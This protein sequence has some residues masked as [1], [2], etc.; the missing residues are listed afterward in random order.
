MGTTEFQSKLLGLHDN[1]LNFAIM[2][3]SN[4]ENAYDLVQ[5]TTLKAL[6]SEDK[7]TDDSNF[8]GWD[9][10]QKVAESLNDKPKDGE[11]M[12]EEQREAAFAEAREQKAAEQTEVTR[13]K[14]DSETFAALTAAIGLEGSRE[15]PSAQGTTDTENAVFLSWIAENLVE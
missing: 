9:A 12:T 13:A 4:R 7:F 11:A 5:D 2:L 14:M 15:M 3:T 1:L 8:K 10:M 6:S